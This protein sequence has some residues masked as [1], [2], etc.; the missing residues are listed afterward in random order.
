MPIY[1]KMLKTASKSAIIQNYI[2][3]VKAC[4]FTQNILEFHNICN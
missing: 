4:K 1:F 3:L 2:K